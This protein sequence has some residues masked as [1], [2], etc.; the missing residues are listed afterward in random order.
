LYGQIKTL[1]KQLILMKNAL[2]PSRLVKIYLAA[3]GVLILV[4]DFIDIFQSGGV[5]IGIKVVFII[6]LIGLISMLGKHS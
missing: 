5:L 4:N 1:E 3:F 2:R 6:L